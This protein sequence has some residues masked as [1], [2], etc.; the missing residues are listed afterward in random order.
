[1]GESEVDIYAS[2]SAVSLPGILL[3]TVE[4]S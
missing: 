4:L 3:C 2:W 1:M